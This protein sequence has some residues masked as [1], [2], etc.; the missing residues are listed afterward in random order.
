MQ[1]I[2]MNRGPVW[3]S[4]TA[5]LLMITGACTMR[6]GVLENPEYLGLNIEQPHCT[7]YPFDDTLSAINNDPRSSPYI[8]SLNGKWKFHYAPDPESRPTDFY[9]EDYDPDG[10]E[11]IM[12]PG[13]WEVQ[14]F[15][16]AIYLDEEYPFPPDPPEIPDDNPVGSYKKSFTLPGAWEGRQVYLVL[17]SVKSAGRVW[18]NGQEVGFV[19][20][21]KVP[22]EF[23]I[24]GFVRP[25]NNSLSIEVYRWSDG[26]YLEGQDTWRV[27]GL[28]REVYLAAL[29]EIHIRDFFVH[30]GL[31]DAYRNGILG[32]E[33]DLRNLGQ[34]RHDSLMLQVKLLS[35][36]DPGLSLYAEQLIVSVGANQCKEIILGDTIE[37]PLKWT[38][39]TPNLYILLMTLYDQQGRIIQSVSS[40]VGFREVEISDTRLL[41]NGIPVRV[42]GVNR[43]EHD[44]ISCK[45]ITEESMLNDIRLMK[46]FNINAVRTSHYPNHPRWYELCDEYGIYLVDEA[47]IESHGMQF[48]PRG[49]FA[50]IADNPRWQK[51]FLDRVSRMV[52]RDKNHPSVIIWSLGN[53][54]G[55]GVNFKSAY[56]W[57]K[58][59]DF[60]R[61]VQYEPAGYH[62]HTDIVC[63]MYKGIS[64][65][66]AYADTTIPKPLILCEYAHAMGNSVG[67]LQ[68]YWDLIDSN[69]KLQGGFIWDWCDQTFLKHTVDGIPYWAYGGDMGD[70]DIPNDS[71]F[72]ANGLVQANRELHPHIWEVKK[73]YQDIRVQPVDMV[74]GLYTIINRHD[75]RDL[76]GYRLLCEIMAEGEILGEAEIHDINVQAGSQKTIRVDLKPGQIMA[77]R[78]Y[79]IKFTWVTSV[80]QPLIPE[81]FKVAWDQYRL[82]VYK[83]QEN[84]DRQ[85]QP[86]IFSDDDEDISV[87]GGSMK[88]TFEK[89]TGRISSLVYENKEYIREGLVPNFWRSPVD[90]DLGNAM[91][92]RCAVWKH[93]G[94]RVELVDFGIRESDGYISVHSTYSLEGSD[95]EVS[96][97]YQVFA[98]EKIH[99]DYRF[100]PGNNDLPEIPRIGTRMILCVDFQDLTWFGR[101]PHENYADRFTGAAVDLYRGSV[102]D[103]YHPYVRPQET[104][105]KTDVRWLTLQ[106]NEGYGLMV[107]ADS[108][109]SCSAWQFMPDALDHKQPGEPNRHGTDIHPGNVITLNL[110]LK[111]TG[112]GGNNSWGATP[113]DQYRIFPD[114]PFRYGFT[115]KP[116]KEKGM[117]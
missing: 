90:N 91:P 93:A 8:L 39:E 69:P 45:A 60:S 106:D 65:L 71:N 20:G 25:G 30:A 28:E 23:N 70:F 86:L 5:C 67:N 66:K 56:S 81:G 74:A 29:P 33:A 27:S 12:V 114:H 53:E 108:L 75:F 15:G 95:S 26:S 36:E 79:F 78:E 72:C 42:K 51:A 13:N 16:Q 68:D 9:R 82:P 22:A 87:Q 112:V 113:L 61:P 4:L 62:D 109:L 80:D 85:G 100:N 54:A 17:A 3:L 99:V 105:N 38:A 44:M 1:V 58:S 111:Q 43:H 97:V 92:H 19:K 76:S 110:D 117:P 84:P 32:L 18:V 103:Q 77:N 40:R 7:Y 55:D 63:P 52:E 104:G 11:D 83:D 115:L 6:D 41:V 10:W 46:Q 31:D 21:S 94:D 88:V 89:K 37:D 2:H 50:L 101:G 34:A 96:L 102:W 57:I 24:T 98:S 49:G 35:R 107:R 14:G 116:Y 47:N 73:V 48:N 64:F 59:R